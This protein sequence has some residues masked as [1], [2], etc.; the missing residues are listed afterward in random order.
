[1]WPN[2]TRPIEF[3]HIVVIRKE[4][5]VTTVTFTEEILNGKL[6]LLS[7]GGR[8]FANNIW[9]YFAECYA[10][11]CFVITKQMKIKDTLKAFNDFKNKQQDCKK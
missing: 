9:Q 8:V 10:I 7:S 4:N 11:K 2:P 1:M 3:G 6:H 5:D